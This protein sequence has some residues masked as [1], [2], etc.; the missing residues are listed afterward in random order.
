MIA[1]IEKTLNALIYATTFLGFVF[2]LIARG[3]VPTWL[4]YSI[5][6]G[7]AIYLIASFLTFFKRP[8]AY[9]ISMVL[10]LV[11]IATSIPQGVHYQFILRGEYLFAT[12][13]LLGNLLQFLTIGLFIAWAWTRR[14]KDKSL[15]SRG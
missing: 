9:V 7:F 3:V 6:A 5:L 12:V 10:A 4:Y 1:S 8:A 14:R 15:E 13:F 2:L 11:V